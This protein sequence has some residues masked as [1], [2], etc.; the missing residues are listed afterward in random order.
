MS[1]PAPSV[2]GMDENRP[3]TREELRLALEAA[4]LGPRQT[5]TRLD[6]KSAYLSG[7]EPALAITDPATAGRA[8]NAT[9]RLIARLTDP[10]P[11]GVH[12]TAAT[13]REPGTFRLE[14]TFAWPD[15]TAV[16]HWDAEP[17][18]AASRI[19]EPLLTNY[20]RFARLHI[21]NRTLAWPPA[22]AAEQE[23]DFAPEFLFAESWTPEGQIGDSPDDPSAVRTLQLDFS[24]YGSSEV[25]HA[26]LLHNERGDLTVGD[27]VLL[28]GDTVDAR[29]F[30]VIDISAD[31]TDYTFRRL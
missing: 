26:R 30:T 19:H 13:I 15:G 6:N 17:Y 23:L 24:R 25:I 28:S 31:G 27:T 2:Q 16:R 4:G 3:G 7:V 20:P 1:V 8:R 10:V 21:A 14:L 22:T 9:R 29:P 11:D 12:V 18:L 5:A